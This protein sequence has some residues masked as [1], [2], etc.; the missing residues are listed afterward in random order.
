M[1][2]VIKKQP[3]IQALQHHFGYFFANP[4]LLFQALTHRSFPRKAE[5]AADAGSAGWHNERLEFLGDA[6][7][8]LV[9]SS[10]LFER[11]ADASEGSLSHW[12]SSLV[13]TRS[14]SEVGKSL[15]L[16]DYLQLGRGEA[17]SGGREKTSILGNCLEALFGA[18]FLDGGFDAAKV[19]IRQLLKPRLDTL[20]HGRWD[21]DYKT[22][23]QEYL[24]SQGMLLPDYRV[25]SVTGAPHE[26]F[27]CVECQVERAE[28]GIGYGR[29]KRLAEQAA[30]GEVLAGL[31]PIYGEKV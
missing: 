10:M 28:P 26:R 19:V 29:S 3:D 16:G 11:H 2:E 20:D 18:I 17:L 24:Q 5:D 8:D 30:A 1:G 27:F 7:L 22:L 12:R 25:V 9:V 31:N 4:D 23:L 15:S 21:K 13:N 14:L 6:V